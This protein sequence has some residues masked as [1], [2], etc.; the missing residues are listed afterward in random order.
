MRYY[1]GTSRADFEEEL[2]RRRQESVPGI[3][4]ARDVD[5]W[6]EMRASAASLEPLLAWWE[7]DAADGLPELPYPPD[8]PKMPGEPPRVQPSRARRGAE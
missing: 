6:A 1:A 2:V 4:A 8:F 7:R 3:V 5:P